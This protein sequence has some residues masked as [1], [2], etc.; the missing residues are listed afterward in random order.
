MLF[1]LT[2][3]YHS[4]ILTC[5]TDYFLPTTLGRGDSWTAARITMY[6]KASI[7][8]GQD[9]FLKH[10]V[11]I[12]WL[13]PNWAGQPTYLQYETTKIDPTSN[14]HHTLHVGSLNSRFPSLY[15]YRRSRFLS[16]IRPVQEVAFHIIAS[17]LRPSAGPV[18][19]AIISAG[20]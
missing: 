5:M 19:L 17:T 3:I 1:I 16:S 4:L 12:I 2:L 6:S 9:Q 8:K 7:Y 11:V 14:W 20:A 18:L 13:L 15:Y 10:Y